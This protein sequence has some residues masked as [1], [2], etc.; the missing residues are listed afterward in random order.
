MSSSP[1][2]CFF[3][4]TYIITNAK[5]FTR[6]ILD[7]I[8]KVG[9]LAAPT[10]LHWNQNPIIRLPVL[11]AVILLHNEQATFIIHVTIPPVPS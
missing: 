6:R 9:P 7:L 5:A 10:F 8:A 3:C 11:A 2:Y 1:G 4:I